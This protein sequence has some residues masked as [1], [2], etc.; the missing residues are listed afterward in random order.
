MVDK[1]IDYEENPP[2]FT[3]NT[4]ALFVA[5]DGAQFETFAEDLIGRLPAGFS[6]ERVYVGDNPP[7]PE[8]DIITHIDNGCL[9]VNY[10][11]HGNAVSWAAPVI[12]DTSTIP[13][14]NNGNKLPVVTI[15]DCFNGY[16]V[17]L[18]PSVAE[19]FIR[20][21]N[22]GAV[23]VWAATSLGFT[24][25]HKPLIGAFYDEIFL[26]GNLDL[27]VATTLAKLAIFLPNPTSTKI[28]ETVQT[29]VFFGDPA[30]ELGMPT[31][32]FVLNTTPADG[33][34][35]V[36]VDQSIDI[37]FSKPISPATINLSGPGTVGSVFTPTLSNG[38]RVVSFDHTDFNEGDTLF[39]TI[40]AQDTSGNALTMGPVPTTWSFTVGIGQVYLP[41]ILSDE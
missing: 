5:D 39:F 20:V 32:P 27:G 11:G 23:A 40:D 17:G 29:F 30:L 22:K 14:L 2:D 13:T 36:P 8:G 24:S 21:E 34:S 31:V 9:L 16:F 19:E 4:N 37:T 28:K 25:D 7:D 15:G 6:P 18:F 3:W 41:V 33:A 38:D 10:G 1:I 26:N 12:F 35:F